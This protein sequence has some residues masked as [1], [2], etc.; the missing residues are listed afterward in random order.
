LQRYFGNPDRGNFS[1]GYGV[2][3]SLVD[4]APAVL[5]WYYE[6]ASARDQFV[7]GPSGAGY[8]FPSRMPAADLDRFVGRLNAEMGQA[9]LGIAE[10]LED[11]NSFDRVDLWSTYL[12]QP[13][14][15]ALFYLGPD[16][17]GRIGW[18]NGKPVIGQRDVLWGGA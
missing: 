1:V 13:N 12:R 9:D 6:N 14:I 7:A 18:V 5:R 15:D 8:I 4:L 2:S 10:I 3:P 17:N 16:A 11:Q